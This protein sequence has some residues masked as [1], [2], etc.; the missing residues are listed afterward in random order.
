MIAHLRGTVLSLQESSGVIDV[1]GVGYLAHISSSTKAALTVGE[2][3]SLHIITVVREDDLSL[4]GFLDIESK[5]TF[6]T[7]C[8][9]N[10]VGPKL[11]NTILGNLSLP[12]LYSALENN[13]IAVLSKIPGI[14]KRTAERLCLELKGK[15]G[16]LTGTIPTQI[17]SPRLRESD[18]LQLALA[19]L[20]YRK[21][22]IDLVLKSS[23]VPDKTAAS[24]QDRLRAALRFL[25]TQQ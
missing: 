2:E 14:G 21:S 8:K 9:V 22:E 12:E 1:Q 19:Q 3:A 15:L 23:E 18:P 11:A 20:D 17:V 4:Y 16:G 24:L 6:E 5:H 25:A 10:K 7:L 13:Q